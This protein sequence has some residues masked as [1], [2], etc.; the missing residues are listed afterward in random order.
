MCF[1]S[2]LLPHPEPPRM[3]KTSPRRTSNVTFS[4][5]MKS[6]Y[7]AVR[8]SARMIGSLNGPPR[9]RL[10]PLRCPRRGSN[11]RLGAALR[12]SCPLRFRARLDVQKEIDDR[13]DAVNDNEQ[14]DAR[15]DCPRCGIADSR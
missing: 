9:L 15:N 5:K 2:V 4:S 6:P 12:R 3:T 11:S 7:P 13:K 8:P 10:T 1:S 14:D